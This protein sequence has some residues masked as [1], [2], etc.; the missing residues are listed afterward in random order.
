MNAVGRG[1]KNILEIVYYF[2]CEGHYCYILIAGVG[3]HSPSPNVLR[4]QAQNG[5]KCPFYSITGGAWHGQ[6]NLYFPMPSE[7]R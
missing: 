4:E 3:Y 1:T 2:V 7:K 6:S 5:G